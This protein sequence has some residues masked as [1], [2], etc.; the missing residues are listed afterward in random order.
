MCRQ[1]KKMPHGFVGP[2]SS[3][4]E[5]KALYDFDIFEPVTPWGRRVEGAEAK[6]RALVGKGYHL[7]T[8]Q[9]RG[10]RVRDLWEAGGLEKAQTVVVQHQI[11]NADLPAVHLQYFALRGLAELPRLILEESGTP[12]VGTYYGRKDFADVKP[13]LPLG[14]VP[15]LLDFDGQG[16]M[17]AQSAAIVRHLARKVGLAGGTEQEVALAD[18]LYETH[19]ELFVTH[20]VWGKVFDPH[21]LK[22]V[23]GETLAYRVTTNGGNYTLYQ[24]SHAA[25]ATFED[26]LVKTGGPYL[27]G[28]ALTFVDLALWA[29]LAEVEEED[30]FPGALLALGFEAL[31]TFKEA[32]ERRPNILA[33]V[34]SERRLP[35]SKKVG[36]D[37]RYVSGRF[38]PR[39]ALG[40]D[41]PGGSWEKRA[42]EL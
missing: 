24:T 26:Q 16:T 38:E 17:L 19:Q 18:M 12:Y 13:A 5:C 34:N 36:G 20:G 27:C 6:K 39:S 42:G 15:V 21:A 3:F 32:V 9:E 11:G 41:R 33:Y 30:N 35:R 25:L 8:C 23:S 22:K 40:G 1:P 28:A 37:Y 4:H 14:R 31:A 29:T 7:R 2:A 10:G